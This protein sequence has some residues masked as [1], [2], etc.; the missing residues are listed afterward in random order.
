DELT[1]NPKGV[2]PDFDFNEFLKGL[3][4]FSKEDSGAYCQESCKK[5]GG[6][7]CKNRLCVRERG[8]EICYGCKDFPCEHFSE[9][10]DKSPEKLKDYERFNKLGFEE[11]LRFHAERAEKGYAN[12]TRKYYTQAKKEK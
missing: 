7:S 6:V 5:G 4:Y 1:I 9:T 2:K 12:A 8:L 10:I 3:E 11:W